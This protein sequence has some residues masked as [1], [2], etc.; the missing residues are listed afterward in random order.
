M[1]AR[2]MKNLSSAVIVL[3]GMVV[4]AWANSPQLSIDRPAMANIHDLV[5][6]IDMIPFGDVP[7]SV[8]SRR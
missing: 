7:L 5:V 6:S 3:A 1:Q 2:L 4:Q 8:E